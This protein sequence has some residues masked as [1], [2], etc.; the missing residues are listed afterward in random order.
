MQA[1]GAM[2]SKLQLLKFPAYLRIVVPSGNMLRHDWGE[3]GVIEN[4]RK[5]EKWKLLHF[6]SA[7]GCRTC[8][9]YIDRV[10]G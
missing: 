8:N 10:I 3:Q 4:V 5:E 1:M 6:R 2:H 7:I 9:G